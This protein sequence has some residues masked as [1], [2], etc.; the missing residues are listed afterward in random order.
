MTATCSGADVV[1][2]IEV[3][4]EESQAITVPRLG[5]V[6]IRGA[7]YS[8]G[9]TNG[10]A[11]QQFQLPA[12]V[13]GT[14]YAGVWIETSP[15]SGTYEFYPAAGTVGIANRTDVAGKVVFITSQGLLRIGND[16]GTN[17][18]YVPASGCAIRIPNVMLQNTTSANRA[19]NV[20]PSSTA[21]SRYE[22]ATTTGG[23]IDFDKCMCAWYLNLSQP[24]AVYLQNTSIFEIFTISEVT[25]PIVFNNVGVGQAYSNS[26]T[27]TISLCFSGGTFTDCWFS[28]AQVSASGNYVLT[29]TDCVDLVFT[30]TNLRVMDAKANASVG[31][32]TITR[33][34]N[35]SW[36]GVTAVG[37]KVALI[38]TSSQLWFDTISYCDV[39]NGTTGTANGQY[40]FSMT[41]F[42]SDIV[43]DGIDHF[44]LTN[45]HPYT[46]CFQII[47][48][49]NNIRVRNIGTPSS[50]LSLGSANA[51]GYFLVAAA[52]ASL[53]R[54][55]F[56]R[57]YV[58]DTR[59]GIM[60]NVDNSCDGLEFRNC[61]FDT[62]DTLT[63]TVYNFIIKGCRCT[64]S[65]T[66]QTQVCGV[67]WFDLFTST[68]AG[69]LGIVFDEKS[70]NRDPSEQSYTVVQLGTSSGFD[71]AGSL[72]MI[73]S[74]DEVQYL[75]PYWVLGH[76]Q[77][78]T[79]EA[80]LTGTSTNNID[81][82]YDIDTGSGF[83]GSWRN[84][85]YKRTGG[86]TTNTSPTISMTSTTGVA[87]GDYVYGTNIP[88]DTII[89]SID[90]STNCTMS[91]A[92][93]GT[94]S[95]LTFRF[96]A[97]PI[98]VGVVELSFVSSGYVSCVSSD[99][100]KTVQYSGGSPSDSGTLIAYNNT[101]RTWWVRVTNSSTFSNT[102]TA[103]VIASGTGTGT[104]SVAGTVNSPINPATGF[105]MKIRC[106]VTTATAGALIT[107]LTVPT[108]TDSTSQQA[109]YALDSIVQRGQF[110]MGFN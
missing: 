13:T 70:Y 44:G 55:S 110:N 33:C 23:V 30:N 1:G 103:I 78:G 20:I 39:I 28:R 36:S 16:S 67:H 89:I 66:G 25:Q 26:M 38:T 41:T 60:Q 37:A 87:V 91:K 90:S 56:A 5:K 46:G 42:C 94:A 18:G 43:I 76:T 73:N 82:F 72:R 17:Y 101:T 81:F 96:N 51:T 71:G 48:A 2:W 85:N 95:S 62:G 49:S 97:L 74:A 24:Y 11:N 77:F 35:C 12:P 45:V 99:I 21:T 104:L 52:G 31:M 102:A 106:Y 19:V 109:Q 40:Y 58:S 83:L 80:T 53:W 8:V 27:C 3:V 29:L 98:K 47:V 86:S 88:A 14:Y 54:L 34:M 7:W 50:V 63:P 22:F 32:M 75:T 93:T 107:Y 15:S 10:S 100:E 108:V 84:L 68:T 79:A 61:W 59:S 69:R 65:T 105:R 57:I 6:T 92:A 64:N 4:A 9:S